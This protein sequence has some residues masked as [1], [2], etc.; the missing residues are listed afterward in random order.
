MMNQN[1]INLITQY[2]LV[3][4]VCLIPV[5][6]WFFILHKK[7]KEDK[8]R[9]IVT[10]LAGCLS[11][12][13]MFLWNH[14]DHVFSGKINIS[15]WGIEVTHINIYRYFVDPSG[16][17]S[18]GEAFLNGLDI[19]KIIQF[20]IIAS[21]IG[22]ILYVSVLLI[23]FFIDIIYIDKAKALRK[24]YKNSVE[25]PFIFFI[26]AIF[27]GVCIAI[28]YNIFKLFGVDENHK[29][30]LIQA[31]FWW[32]MM[33]GFL[34]EY[35]KHLVVRFTDGAYLRSVESAI[36]FSI[37]VGL[38]FAFVENIIYL[39]NYIWNSRCITD[40]S[41]CVLIIDTGERV[42][43][44]G[45]ILIPYILR[46][47]LSMSAHVVFSGIFGYYYGLAHFASYKYK[48]L[49]KHKLDHKIIGFISKLTGWNK[50][51][52]FHNIKIFE[53]LFIAMTLHGI[54]NF[55]L[56]ENTGFVKV[57]AL[58]LIIVLIGYLFFLFEQ[59]EN[60]KKLNLISTVRTSDI[61]K[62]EENIK[63]LELLEKQYEKNFKTGKKKMDVN[64]IMKNAKILE[65]I[66]ENI[67][68]KYKK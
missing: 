47:I 66:E 2:F 12:I 55:S 4:T 36:S 64:Q 42:H 46:S 57:I 15:F 49:Q 65:K 3:G 53:G 27:I 6:V 52:L 43:Q 7:S 25:E 24:L 19:I 56:D 38:G 35:T 63:N 14:L 17:I 60:N 40:P 11:V 62:L 16:G 21:I 1:I 29:L 18:L 34:E 58:P 44:V 9:L 30:Y 45:V 39:V 68:K 33:V 20:I 26:C 48:K 51:N 31:I 10:F 37:V 59:K 22:L 32:S 28:V 23:S 41:Q 61:Q 54:F 13:P 50:I 5:I 67:S 8:L